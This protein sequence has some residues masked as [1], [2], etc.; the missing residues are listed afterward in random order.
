MLSEH[1]LDLQRQYQRAYNNTKVDEYNKLGRD[2]ALVSIALSLE[3][4]FE[5]DTV[6]EP[7]NAIIENDTSNRQ[8]TND[9][10]DVQK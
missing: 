6:T 10:K 3:Q 7:L 5:K 9:E 1:L 2:I 8:G 4:M